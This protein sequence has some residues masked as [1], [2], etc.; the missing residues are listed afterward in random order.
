MKR[1]RNPTVSL[2]LQCSNTLV[3]GGP[4]GHRLGTAPGIGANGV[5][6]PQAGR[7]GACIYVHANPPAPGRQGAAMPWHKYPIG[8]GYYD[9]AKCTLL[10]IDLPVPWAPLYPLFNKLTLAPSLRAAPLCAPVVQ[11]RACWGRRIIQ[12]K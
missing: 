5:R 4:G 10:F 12:E 3:R 6:R 1:Q 2:L 8:N 9:A 7:K 11:F